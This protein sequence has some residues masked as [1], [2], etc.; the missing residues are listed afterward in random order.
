MA[1]GLPGLGVKPICN[2]PLRP[3]STVNAA[4]HDASRGLAWP[5][6]DQAE[7]GAQ[8]RVDGRK[9]FRPRPRSKVVGAPRPGWAGLGQL[10]PLAARAQ[11][12]EEGQCAT[13]ARQ[14]CGAGPGPQAE[15]S[16][17]QS[18]PLRGRADSW[19]NAAPAWRESAAKEPADRQRKIPAL[20]KQALTNP[21]TLC[22]Y[23]MSA[24]YPDRA[25][26]L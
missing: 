18:N 16:K 26:G 11:Q 5:A 13:R 21:Q 24:V 25:K 7:V 9:Q 20:F 10:A 22:L 2:D 8:L 15:G 1:E 3:W 6:F 12:L 23:E 4:C 17:R 19:D 14:A